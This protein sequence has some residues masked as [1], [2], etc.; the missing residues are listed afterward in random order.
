MYYRLIAYM[1]ITNEPI[2]TNLL[3]SIAERLHCIRGCWLC[4][5]DDFL[6]SNGRSINL[7][8]LKPWIAQEKRVRNIQQKPTIDGVWRNSRRTNILQNTQERCLLG[9]KEFVF[10]ERHTSSDCSVFIMIRFV[11][12]PWKLPIHIIPFLHKNIGKNIRFCTYTLIL[13][14]SNMQPKISMLVRSHFSGF[15]KLTVEY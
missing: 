14:I 11:C 10:S 9:I 12:V 6:M 7:L 3:F 8:K 5:Y 15:M 13:M 1:S 4:F 2:S